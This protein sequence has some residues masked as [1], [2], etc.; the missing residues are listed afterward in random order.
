[1]LHVDLTE[2]PRDPRQ[3]T[4]LKSQEAETKDAKTTLLFSG[5]ESAGGCPG[6]SLPVE[7]EASAR[8]LGSEFSCSP[9]QDDEDPKSDDGQFP[10]DSDGEK[11]TLSF[12]DAES[13]EG[14]PEHSLPIKGDASAPVNVVSKKYQV[15]LSIVLKAENLGSDVPGHPDS[16]EP[17]T[18]DLSASWER[19]EA[20]P[21]SLEVEDET[22][23]EKQGSDHVRQQFTP[24]ELWAREKLQARLLAPDAQDW[25]RHIEAKPPTPESGDD[26][27][28]EKQHVHQVG[29]HIKPPQHPAPND[30]SDRRERVRVAHEEALEVLNDPERPHSAT[31]KPLLELGNAPSFDELGKVANDFYIAARLQEGEKSVPVDKHLLK[32]ENSVLVDKQALEGEN[33]VP[34]DE[35]IEHGEAGGEDERSLIE[36]LVDA[37]GTDLEEFWGAESRPTTP[38]TCSQHSVRSETSSGMSE[39]HSAEDQVCDEDAGS[40]PTTTPRMLEL[41]AE[42]EEEQEPMETTSRAMEP[43]V[44]S[45]EGEHVLVETTDQA[46]NINTS[47]REAEHEAVKTTD[48]AIDI[49]DT[50]YTASPQREPTSVRL[51]EQSVDGKDHAAREV[52]IEPE[53]HGKPTFL[54]RLSRSFWK[55][56]QANGRRFTGGMEQEMPLPP[57]SLN[58]VETRRNNYPVKEEAVL[59]K[60]VREEAARI[61]EKA[62]PKPEEIITGDPN[63]FQLKHP[64]TTSLEAELES[65]KLSVEKP[66]VLSQAPASS[67]TR[68]TPEDESPLGTIGS[69][70]PEVKRERE[71]DEDSPSRILSPARG[72]FPDPASAISSNLP[73][74]SSTICQESAMTLPHSQSP[75]D[76]R[77]K[78]EHAKAEAALEGRTPPDTPASI[79]ESGSPV[80]IHRSG[81]SVL[82]DEVDEV[83]QSLGTGERLTA[84]ILPSPGSPWSP[85]LH[86]PKLTPQKPWEQV[87]KAQEALPEFF[88]SGN[89]HSR[90]QSMV[91]VSPGLV[92]QFDLQPALDERRSTLR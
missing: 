17:P 79:R 77:R 48:Q 1:M 62:K 30:D 66:L 12:N 16:A 23:P 74:S 40:S 45:L 32:G 87:M 28:F 90:A 69:R 36:D 25:H 78:H 24:D 54:Q 39:P 51:S 4:S 14:C 42:E 43:E 26:I 27:A 29:Q 58:H 56:K 18:T 84:S 46:T 68:Q 67:E 35:T 89:N 88:D 7:D 91:P 85:S 13:A 61:D 83:A 71:G 76:R 60:S 92:R 10:M 33:P 15:P 2:S 47:H 59:P 3:T 80:T 82:Q 49:E 53:S 52:Y 21:S 57:A 19:V 34:V 75:E 20:K 37:Q 8:S 22:A 73:Q 6:H 81:I 9:S 55:P 50:L 44:T 31:V 5:A 65:R 70:E 64:A 11:K 38:T 86:V 41:H 63:K 72:S